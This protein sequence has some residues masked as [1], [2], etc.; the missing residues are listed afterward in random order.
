MTTN[1]GWLIERAHLRKKAR[2]A[3]NNVASAPKQ[4]PAVDDLWKQLQEET[5]R[6]AKVFADAVGDPNA[7]TVNTPPDQIEVS[8]PDGRQLILRVDRERRRLSQSFRSSG[9]AVRIRKPLLAFSADADGAAAFNFGG[10]SA[11]AS[12]L[13]RRL[14]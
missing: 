6:Q 5:A 14:I 13:L 1:P 2:A 9:G 8:V 4:L 12:S 3:G 10:L 11:A 7:V